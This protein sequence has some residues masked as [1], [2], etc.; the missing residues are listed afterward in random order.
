MKRN[1]IK[2]F[3]VYDIHDCLKLQ[4]DLNSIALWC[5]SWKLSLNISKCC[6][7]SF[8]LNN[9]QISFDY[10]LN[11]TKFLR[12]AIIKD[13]GIFQTCNLNFNVHIDFVIKK[14][15]KVFGYVVRNCK[16]FHN[17][18]VLKSLYFS[19][20]RPHLEFAAV[21]WCPFNLANINKIKRVQMRFVRYLCSKCNLDYSLHDHLYWCHNFGIP[22]LA[23]RH[24][25]MMV[26]FIYKLLYGLISCSELLSLISFN[27]P[28]RN[29]RHH[30]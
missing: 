19:L 25:S 26:L 21:A 16:S 14:A 29:V 30:V 9:L 17:T 24:T 3:I 13:I 27:I 15:R 2:P 5:Q 23:Q 28:T 8:T 22:T 18:L 20:V 6:I 10:P 1:F 4:L 11:C 12:V 7:K